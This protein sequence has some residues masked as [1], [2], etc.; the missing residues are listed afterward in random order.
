MQPASIVMASFSPTGTSRK[1]GLAIGEGLGSSTIEEIN[2]T[3]SSADSRVL[4]GDEL[5]I[6][7]LPV[8][9]GRVAPQAVERMAG[10]A[11][12][13]APAVAVVLYGNREFEDALLE[14]KN[15]L[16]EKGFNV[17][18]AA[19]FIGEHSFSTPETPIA[20]GR[21]DQH[22]LEKAVDFGR[23]LAGKKKSFKADIVLPGNFPYKD[24]VQKN[25]LSPR[26]DQEK[27]VAC[28]SCEDAC[29]VGAVTVEKEVLFDGDLCILCCACIKICP[30]QALAM[31]APPML[32][33]AQWLAANYSARKEPEVFL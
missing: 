30:E 20:A 23:Q 7:S 12:D 4:S 3:H 6:F 31:T 26:V 11:A 13:G 25:P 15:I 28:K 24:G 32:E 14:L 5:A 33:K 8:Y 19:A 29:P 22:D 16:T 2:L 10:L 18:G 9:A 1:I 17:I 27:C 21:P